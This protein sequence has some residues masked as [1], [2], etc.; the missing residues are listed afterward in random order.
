MTI[1]EK[2]IQEL[3]QLKGSIQGCMPVD[4]CID[5]LTKGSMTVEQCTDALETVSR[6][7]TTALNNISKLMP[8]EEDL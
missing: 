1:V 8:E 7:Y 3:S 2:A 5:G 4:A 6:K